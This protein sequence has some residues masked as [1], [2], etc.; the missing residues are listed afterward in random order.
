M[1]AAP[2]TIQLTGAEASQYHDHNFGLVLSPGTL[3][4]YRCVGGGPQFY[5]NNGRPRYTPAFLDQFARERLGNPVRR[6]SEY[7]DRKPRL[8]DAVAAATVA[9][10]VSAAQRPDLGLP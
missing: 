1:S 3:A 2:K 5:P 4:K 6:A 7:R 8:H 10:N 9:E